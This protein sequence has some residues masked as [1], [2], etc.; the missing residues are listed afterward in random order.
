MALN[1]FHERGPLII[2]LVH[3]RGRR[4]TRIG[5]RAAE[6]GRDSS[7]LRSRGSWLLVPAST[8]RAPGR[9]AF[10]EDDVGLHMGRTVVILCELVYYLVCQNVDGPLL[11]NIGAGVQEDG[12]NV[13]E[14]RCIEAA[15]TWASIEDDI[16]W[17]AEES[18]RYVR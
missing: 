11:R 4:P 12:A 15:A 8:A 6:G 13:C 17:L 7:W 14:C 1:P 2:Q 10:A 18:V 16:D 9:Q 5:R 3:R